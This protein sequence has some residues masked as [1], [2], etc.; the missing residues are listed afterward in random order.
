[1]KRAIALV[2]G[3]LA[4]TLALWLLFARPSREA[5]DDIDEA[6]RAA[7]REILEQQEQEEEAP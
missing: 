4:A 1:V 7:L 3:L 5:E 2:V 6:S